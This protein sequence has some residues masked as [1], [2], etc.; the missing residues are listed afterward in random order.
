M[1]PTGITLGGKN[2]TIAF[3]AYEIKANTSNGQFFF[4]W[5]STTSFI[6]LWSNRSNALAQLIWEDGVQTA[7]SKSGTTSALTIGQWHHIELDYRQ[8]DNTV[9]IFLDGSL[10]CSFTETFFSTA[11]TFPMYLGT[12]PRDVSLRLNGYI[13]EVLVTETLL[14]DADFTPP[15]AP[16]D[17]DSDTLALLHFD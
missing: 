1:N 4:F 17:L 13:D 11:K 8:S 5:G 9:F 3:W 10:V 6:L 15:A 12:N 16:Y 7:G 14:H 2:F